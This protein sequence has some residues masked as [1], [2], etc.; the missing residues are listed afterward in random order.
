MT[1][2]IAVLE[3]ANMMLTSLGANNTVFLSDAKK[4]VLAMQKREEVLVK[5]LERIAATKSMTYYDK[6]SQPYNWEIA[7]A[8]LKSIKGITHDKR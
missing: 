5:V 2:L 3:K 6:L 7:E 8:A 1:D 4:E